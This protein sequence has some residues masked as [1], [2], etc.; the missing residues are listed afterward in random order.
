[1]TY[2]LFH[3]KTGLKTHLRSTLRGKW[4]EIMWQG[5]QQNIY[6]KRWDSPTAF[7]NVGVFLSFRVTF[8]WGILRT[9]NVAI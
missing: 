6:E 3:A 7:F 8:F 2:G 1:M 5:R 4:R 9:I